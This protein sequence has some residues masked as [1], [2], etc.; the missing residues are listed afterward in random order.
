MSFEEL[1]NYCN[2]LNES[3][4]EKCLVC[5]IPIEKDGSSIKLKCKHY[6]HSMCIKYKKGKVNCLYCEKT[7]LPEF[8]NEQVVNEQVVN[9]CNIILKTGL[10]KGKECGRINCKYHKN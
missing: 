4:A 8:V 2:K 9:G 1:F 10:N 3:T 5:H 7:S 6:Y